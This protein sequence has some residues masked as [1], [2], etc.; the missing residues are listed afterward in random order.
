PQQGI[1]GLHPQGCAGRRPGAAQW[2]GDLVC[3]GP[4]LRPS[5][6]PLRAVFRHSRRVG[7]SHRPLR[8][9][10]PGPGA[11]LY[12]CASA[13]QRRL[14]RHHSSA[15]RR[16]PERRRPRRRHPHQCPGG[17]VHPPAAG[18]VPLGAPPLQDPARGREPPLPLAEAAPPA[19][20]RCRGRM[21]GRACAARDGP[22]TI[23]L[24]RPEPWMITG[25]IVAMITPMVPGT[26]AVDWDALKKLVEWHIAEGTD[27]IVAVG[28]TGESATLDV[29]EHLEV[30]RV[31]LETARGRIPIIAGTGAN[32]TS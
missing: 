28:T 13:G 25:S 5:P 9:D 24:F 31:C 19:G 10:G 32:S 15:P 2:P 8:P 23:T 1:G 26:L 20:R 12:P 7:H 14:P 16:L 4:G 18:P 17:G 27:G 22:C 6:E 30:I 21:T 29:D 3:A 11:A